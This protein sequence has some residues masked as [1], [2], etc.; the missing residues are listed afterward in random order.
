MNLLVTLPY[1]TKDVGLLRKLINWMA[2][3]QLN[4][5]KHSCLLVADNDVPNDEKLDIM[6]L[7]KPLFAS[8]DTMIVRVPAEKQSWP[9]AP[10]IMFASAARQVQEV[11]KLPWFWL[12][13]DAVPLRAGWLNELASDYAASAKRFMGSFIPAENQPDMPPVHM[14]GCAIYPP[15]AFSGMERILKDTPTKAFDIA[16]AGYTIPR[17][18][19]NIKMQHYWGQRDL[20]PSFRK[21]ATVLDPKNVLT[22]DFLKSSSVLFHRN[23]DGSLIDLLQD[24]KNSQSV[25]AKSP[26]SKKS[27]PAAQPVVA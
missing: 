19:N 15:D 25:K 2:D 14:A 6:N 22:L 20:S 13:P 10:N 3:L 24:Q 21:E 8:V 5:A 7:V 12:E 16:L 17:A 26:V 18:A 4:Y 9:L 27:A 11:Y 23:K 1:C